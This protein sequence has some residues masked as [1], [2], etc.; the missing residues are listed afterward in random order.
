MSHSVTQKSS[1][2]S[3]LARLAF[4]PTRLLSS[5]SPVK[6]LNGA[7]SEDSAAADSSID[8]I[9]KSF[10]G[11]L[12]TASIYAGFQ[13]LDDETE[14]GNGGLNEEEINSTSIPPPHSIT[15]ADS[16]LQRRLRSRRSKFELSLV[17]RKPTLSNERA[18]DL[19][20]KLRKTFQIPDDAEFISDYSCWLMGDVLLQGHLYI[21]NQC[22]FFSAFLPKK[23]RHKIVQQGALSVKSTRLHRKWAILREG[24]LSIYS[25]STD[26]YF[27]EL[28]LDLKT[29]LRAEIYHSGNLVKEKAS[30]GLVWMKVV[31]SKKTLWFQADSMSSARSWVSAIKKQIFQ[32]RNKGDQ[33]I[34]KIPLQSILDLELTT[35]LGEAKNLRIKVIENPDSYAIDDYF[36]MF[37][38]EGD[39]ATAD[40]HNVLREAGMELSETDEERSELVISKAKLMKESET[41]VQTTNC[42][43]RT[44][45]QEGDDDKDDENDDEN[46]E[47]EEEE[48]E[49]DKEGDH[50]KAT[51]TSPEKYSSW[52][53]VTKVA[54]SG[55]SSLAHPF[56][57]SSSSIL[58][59]NP[60]IEGDPFYVTDSSIRKRK[61][62]SFLKVFSLNEEQLQAFYHSYLVRGLPLYGRLFVGVQNLC[63][64]STLPGTGTLMILPLSD[65]E[66][67][68]K[69]KGFRFG[70][71]GLVVVIHGHEELFFEFFSE[72]ARDD[73]ECQLLRQ[74]DVLKG[75]PDH[76][77]VSSSGVS[78]ALSTPD[79]RPNTNSARIKLVESKLNDEIGADVPIIFE[80]HPLQ[81]TEVRPVKPY[82]L[83]LL[84]IG[85]RGDVQPYIALGKALVKEGHSV[86]IVTH[87]EFGPWI[88]SHGLDFDVIA[89][90]PSELMSLMVSHPS[91]SYSFVRDAKSKFSSWIDE[92]LQSSWKAC[93]DTDVLIE[94]PSSF[95]GIHIA[96]AL[97]VP[98]FRAFTMPWSRTRAYPNAF[99]VPDQKLGGS[100]NYMTH[101]AFENGYWRGV[102]NQVNKW[103]ENTLHI[104]KTNLAAMKQNSVPFL[105]NIS[106]VVFPPSVD[107]PDWVKVT[108][109]WFLNEGGSDY[110]PPRELVNFIDSARKDGK[111]LVYIG[112]GS[113]VVDKPRE[114]S[115]AVIS[116]VVDADV[117]C[118]LNK[119]WSERKAD[120]NETLEKEQFPTEIYSA[121]SV[122]HDWLFPRIDA[123]VHHGGS[124]T[125]G[126]SLKFGLPTVIKPFFGDQKF[127]ASRV[128]DLGCGVALKELNSKSLTAALKEVTTSK[129]I[130]EKAK[131]IGMKIR[132][133]KGIQNAIDAIYSEMEYARSLSVGKAA[134]SGKAR[135]RS[136]PESAAAKDDWLLV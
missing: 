68:S 63:F 136:M 14:D 54:A 57:S 48:E 86:K 131:L 76:S 78:Q 132:E 72:S 34:V 55:L 65:I 10:A 4:S 16:G 18:L 39:K 80:D 105:Y 87:K 85:S 2:S 53:I 117:R 51:S 50:T 13:D 21:T 115:R 135:V 89:G 73:C 134:K 103:R 7:S 20:V 56:S 26:L 74:I 23:P 46:E 124:G 118:I 113:I 126:A 116:A 15:E 125:T 108:G 79:D 43:V 81:R 24:T 44:D 62:Q 61:Q 130:Q 3:V 111:K 98:Y 37:F 5:L 104:G 90:D 40:I 95:A 9:S 35:V 109:Y 133:E 112:F 120:V 52:G 97:Q 127:Y 70:Y 99:L 42:M 30:D 58:H 94:S 69:E 92:L 66:N 31:T 29:A 36:V 19:S 88:K 17:K 91:I 122:P 47:E 6:K 96:E 45:D 59:F 12:T 83:T 102:S 77:A 107:F 110:E 49:E 1:S 82:R 33:A 11:F 100:Y 28:V 64:K 8:G 101:V 22:I 119:G 32:A 114:L 84:T 25:N 41:T 67:A 106:A 75:E 71:S 93:Q 129:R 38:S 121:G 60:K 27:P 128:E 123:A